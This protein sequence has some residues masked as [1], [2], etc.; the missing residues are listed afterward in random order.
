MSQNKDT[1]TINVYRTIYDKYKEKAE[2]ERFGLKEYMN[3]LLLNLLVKEE[4][5]NKLFGHIGFSSLADNDHLVLND[6]KERRLID[7]YLRNNELYCDFDKTA[8]CAHTF[9]V[10]ASPK[11]GKIIPATSLRN[12]M[13]P[14]SGSDRREHGEDDAT[15]TSIMKACTIVL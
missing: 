9:F 13:S 10:W 3:D 5:I 11:M 4:F 8:C 2:R 14:E 6:L 1:V 7:I 15:P 12:R